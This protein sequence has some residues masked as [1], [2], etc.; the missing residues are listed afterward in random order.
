MRD[1]IADRLEDAFL[2]ILGTLLILAIL[3]A[4]Q[5]VFSHEAKNIVPRA[6]AQYR[7]TVIREVRYYWG[8][9]E[10]PA[11]FLSQ[12]HQ[13][14]GF[15]EDAKSAFALGI[16]QFTPGTAEWIQQLY[17]KDLRET[18]PSK[19]GCPLNPKWAIR[20][21]ILYDKRLWDRYPFTSGDDRFGFTLSSYNGGAGWVDKERKAT[22]QM[23]AE[24]NR[25]FNGVE[26][27]CLRAKWACDENRQYP[28]NILHKWRHHY[29]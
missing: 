1:E 8:F 29:Q 6:A 24:S 18:C 16:S 9:G 15:R 7:A 13:E 12:I 26:K 11:T 14:S 2:V 28:R 19:S 3:V 23:N 5:E 27:I 20:S 22:A 21:M 17:A 4:Q 25:W 10:S